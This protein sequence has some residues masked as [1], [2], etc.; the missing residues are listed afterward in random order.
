MF[1]ESFNHKLHFFPYMNAMGHLEKFKEGLINSLCENLKPT[2]DD[3]KRVGFKDIRLKSINTLMGLL[4]IFPNSKFI[5]MFR[6]PLMQWT[7]VRVHR[8]WDYSSHPKKFLKEYVHISDI[9]IDFSRLEKNVFFLEDI[10]I[11]MSS[12]MDNLLNFAEING[13]DHEVIEQK[14]SVKGLNRT[15]DKN[16]ESLIKSHK[17]YRNYLEMKSILPLKAK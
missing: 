6:N 3:I 15:I 4:E 7:S 9:L 13:I 10:E 5:F 2:R 11:D 8:Y 17:A 1:K 16:T 12:K 14:Y